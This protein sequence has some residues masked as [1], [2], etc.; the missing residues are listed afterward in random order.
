MPSMKKMKKAGYGGGQFKTNSKV[1]KAGRGGGPKGFSMSN[2]SSPTMGAG[3]K[4]GGTG[5]AMGT[6]RGRGGKSY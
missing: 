1:P 3:K 2:P 4:P 5:K 6:A